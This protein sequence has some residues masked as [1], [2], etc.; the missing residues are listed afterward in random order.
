MGATKGL[1]QGAGK[2][3]VLWF[4]SA[5]TLTISLFPFPRL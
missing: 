1:E 5:G 3:D 4:Q 2:S